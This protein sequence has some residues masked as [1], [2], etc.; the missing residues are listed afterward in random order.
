MYGMSLAKQYVDPHNL[1]MVTMIHDKMN[2]KRLIGVNVRA[3]RKK[4]GMTQAEL[5]AQACVDQAIVSRLERGNV[6]PSAID[7]LNL[8]EV[9]GESVERLCRG[10]HE[11]MELA[12]I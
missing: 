6:S 3:A 8:A 11:K 1:G 2:A 10:A 5:A 7:L 9:L 12:K 4:L